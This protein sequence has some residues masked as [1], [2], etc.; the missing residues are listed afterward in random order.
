MTE[1]KYD[2][3]P[4]FL[5]RLLNY[6]DL[7]S[8]ARQAAQPVISNSSLK[9]LVLEFPVDLNV[10]RNITARLSKLEDNTGRI[11]ANYRAKLQD[12]DD[13]RQSLLQKA[14]TGELT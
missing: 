9:D 10:Q 13:L 6:M 14:F 5:M 4:E 3:D 1:E 2:F 8:H 7:R 12:L 11:K